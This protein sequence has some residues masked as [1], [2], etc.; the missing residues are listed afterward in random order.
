LQFAAESFVLA[1]RRFEVRGV[2]ESQV[3]P[4]RGA[5][6]LIPSGIVR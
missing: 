2:E 1:L 5:V 4:V 6:G 3:A